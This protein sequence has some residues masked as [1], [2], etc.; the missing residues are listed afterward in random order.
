MCRLP[1]PLFFFFFFLSVFLLALVT[2][3]V[4]QETECVGLAGLRS[5]LE[6]CV[7]REGWCRHS[8]HLLPWNDSYLEEEVIVF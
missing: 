4:Q 2:S 7:F 6:V 1:T 3:P 5:R 8:L